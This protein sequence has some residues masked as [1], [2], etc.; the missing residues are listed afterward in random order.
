MGNIKQLKNN[1]IKQVYEL[2]GQLYNHDILMFK[3]F[4]LWK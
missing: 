2:L 1:V 3:M 4:S